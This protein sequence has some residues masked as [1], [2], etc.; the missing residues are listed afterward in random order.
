MRG[1][2]A[3]RTAAL[4]RYLA[5]RYRVEAILFREP[6]G[7]DPRDSLPAGLIADATVIVLPYHSR[8]P[9]ARA[10]RNL[11]RAWRRVPPL[12]DRFS[13]FAEPMASFARNKRYALGVIEHFWCAPYQTALN[14]FCDSMVLD[15]HNIES[16]LHAARARSASWP[17]SALHRRFAVSTLS[18]EQRWLPRF[19]LILATSD[20]DAD[21]AREIAP[22]ARVEVYP[23]TIP[24]R[25]TP[26]LPATGGGSPRRIAFSGN[27]EYD[28]NQSAVAWFH[29]T[30]WPKLRLRHPGLEWI[31]IGRNPNGVRRIVDS[32]PSVT[33][34]GEVEDAIAEIARAQAVVVPLLAGS[35][36]RVKILEAWAAGVPVVATTIGAEGLPGRDGEHLF[37]RDSPDSFAEAVSALLHSPALREAMAH[38]ARTLY[39]SELTWESGWKR[40]ERLGI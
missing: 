27:L 17:L 9:S 30:V 10:V 12:N 34:T 11:A 37:I 24:W 29:R 19:N 13:G 22:T 35:G 38:R 28:P 16:R 39:E 25:E 23:N 20:R 8:S 5:R 18:M 33:L 15:L 3:I 40:L 26:S 36:T 21:R 32:D 2:G 1:G 31:L 6:D 14:E 4:L 7:A